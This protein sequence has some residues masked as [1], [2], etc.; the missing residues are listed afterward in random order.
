MNKTI[1]VNHGFETEVT[2]VEQGLCP[3]CNKK[4]GPFRDEVSKKEFKISGL[5]QDCQDETFTEMG[6]E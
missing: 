5:C 6:D 2:R 1:M 4:P 3:F